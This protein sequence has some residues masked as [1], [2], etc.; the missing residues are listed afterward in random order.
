M[1]KSIKILLDREQLDNF[2]KQAHEAQIDTAFV[3][4]DNIK[5]NS[6]N[7]VDVMED[8]MKSFGAVLA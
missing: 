8:A 4:L 1:N 3:G 7:H 2:V 6:S 5:R